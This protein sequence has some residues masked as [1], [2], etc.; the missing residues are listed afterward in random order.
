MRGGMFDQQQTEYL[1]CLNIHERYRKF[2]HRYRRNDRAIDR[3]LSKSRKD[4]EYNQFLV[5]E[6]N[7]GEKICIPVLGFVS[8]N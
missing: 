2:H 7:L 5:S 4:L 1:L 8:Q 6:V 3:G